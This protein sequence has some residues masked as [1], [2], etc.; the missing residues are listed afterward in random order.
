[1]AVIVEDGTIIDLANSYGS[2]S[3]ADTYHENMGNTA[4]ADFSDEIKE[5]GLIR[6]TLMLEARYGLRWYGYKT[7]NDD[8]DPKVAQLLGWPRRAVKEIEDPET[9]GAPGSSTLEALKDRD[10]IDIPVNSVPV[11]VQYACFEAAWMKA[12]GLALVPD[13]VGDDKYVTKVKVDVIE[14]TFSENKP[15]VDRFPLIDQLL[16]GYAAVG[17]TNLTMVIGLTQ[18]EVDSINDSNATEDYLNTLGN[19]A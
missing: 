13:S 4:W 9:Y 17:G 12:S 5:A 7:N 10:W 14:Q 18:A 11:N 2:T 8:G 3:A 1:M 19:G 15:A 16:E 6:G